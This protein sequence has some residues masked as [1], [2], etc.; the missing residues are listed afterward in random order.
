MVYGQQKDIAHSYSSG[1]IDFLK[2]PWDKDEL[3][4]RI[5]KIIGRTNSD[6]QWD[7]LKLSSASLTLES[8]S[9]DISIEEYLI[10]KK[11]LENRGEAVPREAL[12]FALWGKYKDDSRVIDMHISNL[13]KK[14]LIL[15][16]KNKLCCGTIKTVR[17]YGYMII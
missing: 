3:E 4:A 7:M 1:C 14:I 9:I 5:L 6:I 11:L 10:L 15:K 13:R 16:K 17:N 12:L 8:S 2:D